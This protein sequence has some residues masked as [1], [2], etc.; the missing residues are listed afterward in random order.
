MADLPGLIEGAHAGAGLG[1][2]F[3]RHVERTRV[4]VHMLD[5]AGMEGRDP[6]G[7][8]ETIRKELSLYD[9]RLSALPEV[10]AL[11][12]MDLPEARAAAPRIEAALQPRGCRCFRISAATGEGVAA[13]VG[14]LC[15]V[16]DD[17]G[18]FPSPF[19]LR[20]EEMEK[21][22]PEV[23]PLSV[24]R[25]GE[26]EFAVR[27]SAVERLVARTDLDSDPALRHLHAQLERLGVLD[28]LERLGAKEGDV[29]RVGDVELDYVID[30]FR[31][32]GD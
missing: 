1:D 20:V 14:H 19:A 25:V 32:G 30:P 11:N 2:R 4:L 26:R 12:K 22:Q 28:R 5:A 10:V 13:L 18:R 3:L 24:E 17:V 16:L 15:Q 29:V 9:E 6:V 23:R 7:D 21:Q 8:Y 27:G 31:E